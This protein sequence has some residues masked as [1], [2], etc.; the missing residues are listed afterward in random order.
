M[1][2]SRPHADYAQAFPTAPTNRIQRVAR[3]VF[4]QMVYNHRDGDATCLE[5]RLRCAISHRLCMTLCRRCGVCCVA[6]SRRSDQGCMLTALAE[7]PLSAWHNE[8]LYATA[9]SLQVC[10]PAQFL[11]GSLLVHGDEHLLTVQD[12]A[13]RHAGH[14]QGA[15]LPRDRGPGGTQRPRRP[16][17]RLPLPGANDAVAPCLT[18]DE[19]HRLAGASV[20]LLITV[21]ASADPDRHMEPPAPQQPDQDRDGARVNRHREARPHRRRCDGLRRWRACH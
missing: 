14:V 19:G 8:W 6:P 16:P 11:G 5:P 12:P 13:G 7:A 20:C 15:A 17:R 21:R 9:P 2:C 18:G 1:M 3:A 4:C 10:I